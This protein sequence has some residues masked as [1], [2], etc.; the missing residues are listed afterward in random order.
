MCSN[1]RRVSVLPGQKRKF[2]HILKFQS[3]YKAEQ[4]R[5]RLANIQHSRA[6]FNEQL[7]HT[8]NY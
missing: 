8:K 1:Y 6:G 3:Y 5:F 4:S 7:K 2:T